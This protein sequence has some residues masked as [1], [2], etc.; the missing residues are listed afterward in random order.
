MCYCFLVFLSVSVTIKFIKLDYILII[1]LFY[2]AFILENCICACVYVC[3]CVYALWLWDF[4]QILLEAID[5]S[6]SKR[7][8]IQLCPF[9]FLVQTANVPLYD[10]VPSLSHSAI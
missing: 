10:I 9:S 4:F 2:K 7:G 1:S 6:N 5:G 3:M 8:Q